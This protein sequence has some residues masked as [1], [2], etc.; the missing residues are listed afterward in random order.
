MITPVPGQNQK[1]HAVQSYD[2]VIRVLHVDDDLD[3]LKSSKQLLEIHGLF[4]IENASSVNEALQLMSE[5]AFDVVISDYQIPERDGLDFLNELRSTGEKV[6]FIL[7]TG[8]GREDIAINALNLGADYYLN[9]YGDIKTVYGQLEHYIKQAAEKNR[10]ASLLKK[11]EEKYRKQFEASMDAI[12]I[13]DAETGVIVDCN[14]EATKLIGRTKSELIGQHQ[15][16]LHLP[17]AFEGDFT[18]NFKKHRTELKK[19]IVE[20]RIVTKSGDVRDVLI[21]ASEFEVNNRRLLQGIFRDITERN[22][23]REKIKQERKT[24]EM[25]TT[26]TGAA[27]AVISKDYHI[28]WANK[29]LEKLCGELKGKLCYCALSDNKGICPKCGVKEIIETGKDKVIH[30][31]IVSSNDGTKRCLE[32]TA[33]PIRDINGNINSVAEMSIDITDR[34]NAERMLKESEQKFRAI[35]DYARD[36]IVLAD[37]QENIVYWNPAAEQIFGYTQQEAVGKK[38]H[39]LLA[40]R[41][42]Q[43]D[44]KLF[45]LSFNASSNEFPEKTREIL[46]LKKGGKQVPVELS[47]KSLRLNNELHVLATVRDI[48]QQNAAWE[49][50]EETMNTLVMVNEKL[51]V[52]GK[53]TRHDVR[54]K[55]AVILNNLYLAKN[56][57]KNCGAV[58]KYCSGIETAVDQMQQI[59]EFSATYEMLGVEELVSINVGKTLQEAAMILDLGNIKVVNQTDDLTVLTDSLLRQLFYNLIDDSLKHGETVNQIRVYYTLDADQLKLIYEDNGAGIPN[60]EKQLIFK[61]GYGKGTGYGLYLIKKICDAYGWTITEEGEQGKGVRFVMTV[62]KLNMKGQ[63]NYKIQQPQVTAD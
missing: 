26:H 22:K 19:Q 29:F 58:S 60:D 4:S 62:P 23:T 63:P 12:F 16:I 50:L 8:K 33:V 1:T 24:L 5:Q 6:P 36:G 35:T 32:I 61:E 42:L 53:L 7:F 15:R 52:V 14:R 57:M 45:F 41:S 51:G 59:F 20:D 47:L 46:A 40:P 25:V 48:S 17:E 55:L 3:F 13:V 30:E 49:S 44:A 18:T 28:I 56:Q 38:I 39:E 31:Q 34:K 10:T 43:K 21:K 37:C 27:L 9:K 54:N 2:D 11:S